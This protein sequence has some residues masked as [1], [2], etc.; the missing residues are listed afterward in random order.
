MG[1]H[2]RRVLRVAGRTRDLFAAQ[3]NDSASHRGLCLRHIHDYR[4]C[5]GIDALPPHA[6]IQLPAFLRARRNSPALAW[7]EFRDNQ[8]AA[9]HLGRPSLL[10][11]ELVLHRS[12][13][14]FRGR[15]DNVCHY[16]L[17][18]SSLR[19]SIDGIILGTGRGASFLIAAAGAFLV[20]KN[21]K[22]VLRH[23]RI[24]RRP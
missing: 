17:R 20:K 19:H 8:A 13:G 5:D 22:L 23:S 24:G 1:S 16:T 6:L 9:A 18:V 11:D 12:G 21:E 15:D 7:A 14:R 10:L 4:Y 2:D 3:S